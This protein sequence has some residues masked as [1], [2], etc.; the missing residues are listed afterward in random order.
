MPD[1]PAGQVSS[2]MMRWLVSAVLVAL[3]ANSMV[4]GGEFFSPRSWPVVTT[5][6]YLLLIVQKGWSNLH[7]LDNQMTIQVSQYC[8]L[9]R[10]SSLAR[11]NVHLLRRDVAEWTG[12]HD[13][14]LVSGPVGAR[15]LSIVHS[16]A[17]L[18]LPLHRYH[19]QPH[20]QVIIGIAS[21]AKLMHFL[22]HVQPE[23]RGW[24]DVFF[25]CGEDF[26]FCTCSFSWNWL[27]MLHMHTA[28][29]LFGTGFK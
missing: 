26:R 20:L 28:H 3:A 10:G 14:I 18:Q 27:G 13:A 22:E 12:N 29:G 21:A 4:L 6:A 7:R 8:M 25:F 16:L 5:C 1:F 15:P 24:G 17:F 19:V 9:C 2:P 11:G 23:F